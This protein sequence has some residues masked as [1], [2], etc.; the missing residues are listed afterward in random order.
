MI[1]TKVL[2]YINGEVTDMDN[3]EKHRDCNID[4][5]TYPFYCSD[6]DIYLYDP[7]LVSQDSEA[8]HE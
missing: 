3:M 5:T 7:R 1:A 4:V 8:D 2:S 6:H